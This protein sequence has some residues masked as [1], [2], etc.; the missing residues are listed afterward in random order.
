[1]GL[2]RSHSLRKVLKPGA[3]IR[4][5]AGLPEDAVTIEFGRF[6]VVRHRRDLL[7][8]ARPVELGGR[9]FDTLMALIDAR[10]TVVGKEEL[11]SRVWPDQV[12]EENSLAA[13]IYVLRKVLGA[14]R[15]L[16]RTVVGRGYQFT[17]EIRATSAAA[18]GPPSRMTNLPETPSELIARDAELGAVAALV[19]EQRLVSLVGAGGIGKT[20]LVLE[21]A[22]HLLSRFPDGV[23]LAELGPLS[24]PELVPATVAGALGLMQV[25][26][27]VS[28]ERRRGC[29]RHP[30]ASAGHRQL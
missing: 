22:R 8:D 18:V 11:M 20:R 3:T 16:I 15:H 14:D 24:S 10:G 2:C 29:D 25:A 6:T 9:A 4:N 23:F 21:S 30:E 5:V 1:M 12:V 19:T 27:P 7:V 26:G 13:Q 17:G 28:S